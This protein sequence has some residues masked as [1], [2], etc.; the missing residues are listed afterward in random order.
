MSEVLVSG[1][2]YDTPQYIIIHDHYPP[3]HDHYPPVHDHY[4]PARS[5]EVLD[6]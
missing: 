3:V 5:T 4:I 2:K 6:P 1:G